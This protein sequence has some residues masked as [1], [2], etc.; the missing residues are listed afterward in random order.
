MRK[1]SSSDQL[2]W[3]VIVVVLIL[4]FLAGFNEA[5]R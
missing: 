4:V 5:W 2:A 3:G 1:T